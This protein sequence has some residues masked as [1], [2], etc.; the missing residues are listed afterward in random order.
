MGSQEWTHNGLSLWKFG[1]RSFSRFGS[2]VRQIN[3]QTHTHAN[4][5]ADERSTPLLSSAWS[6]VSIQTQSLALTSSQSWL[7]LGRSSDNHDWLLANASALI[8]FSPV[9]IQTQRTQ[10]NRLRLD[11]NR[12]WVTLAWCGRG[13]ELLALN[14][15][16]YSA[17]HWLRPFHP[18]DRSHAT[19]WEEGYL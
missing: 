18:T 5:D 2:I 12:A 11:G 16:R 19:K 7:P 15:P 17:L 13:V 1:D 3:R 10:R 14:E 4:T 8:A 9:S 6:P